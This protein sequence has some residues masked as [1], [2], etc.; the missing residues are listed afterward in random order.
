MM[1]ISG[2][3]HVIIY[4]TDIGPKFHNQCI[5]LLRVLLQ[6]KNIPANGKS[7]LRSINLG[8][9]RTEELFLCRATNNRLESLSEHKQPEAATNVQMSLT[10]V[11]WSSSVAGTVS[12]FCIS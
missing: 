6:A 3:G 9:Y 1:K 10:A 12:P 11:L 4:N 5:P 2:V 8:I 7:H